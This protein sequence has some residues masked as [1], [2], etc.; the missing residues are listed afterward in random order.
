MLPEKPDAMDPPIQKPP[1]TS[2]CKASGHGSTAERR[3]S[4]LHTQCC[5]HGALH[6][7]TTNVREPDEG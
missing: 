6:D 5:V 3:T 2:S 4:S 7:L 1:N